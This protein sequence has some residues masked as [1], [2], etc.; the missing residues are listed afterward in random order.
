MARTQSAETRH[1]W[2]YLQLRRNLLRGDFQPSHRFKLSAL[3]SEYEASAS[4]VREALTRLAEQ[5]LVVL[6]PNKGFSIPSL[7]DAEIN[8]LAFVR[9]EIEGLAV[10]RSIELGDIDWEVGVVAAHYQLSI[11]PSATIEEDPEVNERWSQ[12]HRMFHEACAA[13]CSSPR[14]LAFRGQLYDQSEIIRQMAKLNTGDKR[15]V[16]AEHKAIADAVIARDADT[17]VQLLSN[18]I[19]ATRRACVDSLG[20]ADDK[21]EIKQ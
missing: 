19:D 1:Q 14:L 4:V 13:A 21:G 8:D 10:R 12:A 18:H 11:T 2:L 5:G 15:N 17:A 7:M 3:C 9:S 6:E 20:S 16:A